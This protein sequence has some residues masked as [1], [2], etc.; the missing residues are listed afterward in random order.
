MQIIYVA[1]PFRGETQWEIEKNV[2][3]AEEKALELWKAGFAVICPHKMTEHFQ[4]ECP[5]G[6]FI[7]GLLEIL[8][9]CDAIYLLKG[10]MKSEGSRQELKLAKEKGLTIIY[11]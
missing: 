4:G 3:H 7:E 9:K 2:R 10:W 6:A 8:S 1:G 5:D 11:E